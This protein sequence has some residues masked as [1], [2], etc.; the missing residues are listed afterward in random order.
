VD[1]PGPDV[2]AIVG[3]EAVAVGMPQAAATIAASIVRAA[4]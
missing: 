4:A 3:G 2:G 1:S